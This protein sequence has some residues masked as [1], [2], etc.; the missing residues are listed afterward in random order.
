M[1]AISKENAMSRLGNIVPVFGAL[2]LAYAS[3]CV[4]GDNT[5][6]GT[7]AGV[8]I[9]TGTDNTI[10]GTQAGESVTTGTDNT[11]VGYKGGAGVTGNYNIILGED[12]SSAITSGSSN[13]LVGNS[14]AHVSN[15]SSHQLDIGD[16]VY[17]VIGSAEV[18][19]NQ[20]TPAATLDVNGTMRLDGSTSGYVAFKSPAAP[21]SSVTYTMPS[22]DAAISGYVLSSNGAGGLSWVS[23][24]PNLNDVDIELAAGTAASPSLTFYEDTRTGLYQGGT[25]DYL[26]VTTGGVESAAFDNSGNF[27]LNNGS[28]SSAGGYQINGETILTLPDKDTSSIAVGESA[29]AA[30]SV[31]GGSGNSAL[32]NL[33]LTAVTTGFWNTAVGEWALQYST[34]GELNTAVG[35]SAMQGTSASPLVGNANTAI[36]LAALYDLGGDATGNT[37]MGDEAGT[38]ITT[39]TDNTLIGLKSGYGV[40]GNYNIILGEDPSSA[41]TS[42]SSN[43]LIGNSLTLL[44]NSGSNQIDIGDTIYGALDA[45]SGGTALTIGTSSDTGVTLTIAGEGSILVP[46]GTTAERPSSTTNGQIRY[47]STLTALETYVDGAWST[48]ISSNSAIFSSGQLKGG[49]LALSYCPYKGNIKTTASQG[50]YTIPSACLTA[51]IGSMYVGGTA[52]QSLSGFTLY[53]IYLW[54]DSGTWVLDA[55][56]TGHSTNTT[57]GVEQESGDAAKTLVGMVYPFGGPT[58]YDDTEARLVATWDNRTPKYLANGF[59][60]NRTTTS[61]SIAEIYPEIEGYFLTWGDTSF[62]AYAGAIANNT[63]NDSVHSVITIDGSSTYIVALTAQNATNNNAINGALSGPFIASEG[64][65]F[66]TISGYVGAGTGTWYSGAGY[67]L[68]W[69]GVI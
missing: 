24:V 37:A 34:E 10:L 26:F 3:P 33:A 21:T 68:S 8:D 56:T 69:N 13:I 62:A 47:N 63:S 67:G 51:S 49:G 54:N 39:G 27:D 53:Y 17:G 20:P 9:T 28:N 2:L 6:G 11:L 40:T 22:A 25:S 52:S 50:N 12:P 16:L 45:T 4:A 1:D 58:L 64:L 48:I 46:S 18:G 31:G 5:V 61:T 38:S 59:S 41:I 30:Q 29:L 60:A 36:G 55:E 43:I 66:I 32:G 19:I 57:T 7:A 44:T 35:V 65:H 42:G 15:S 14:L 23:D